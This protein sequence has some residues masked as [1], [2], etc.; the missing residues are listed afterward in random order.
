MLDPNYSGSKFQSTKRRRNDPTSS[1]S[2]KQ[3]CIWAC[4][5]CGYTYN[6]DHALKCV[7]CNQ[8]GPVTRFGVKIGG[9]SYLCGVSGARPPQ[10]V[11]LLRATMVKDGKVLEIVLDG[12][13]DIPLQNRVIRTLVRE[14][15]HTQMIRDEIVSKCKHVLK[16]GHP[17]PDDIAD[18]HEN[19]QILAEKLAEYK[20]EEEE[21]EEKRRQSLSGSSRR[22][23]LRG[24]SN[25]RGGG[26]NSRGGSDSRGDAQGIGKGG[27]FIKLEEFNSMNS[28]D[29]GTNVVD[30]ESSTPSLHNDDADEDNGSDSG[31][32]Y[33]SDGSPNPST[34][35]G[36]SNKESR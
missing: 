7:M 33:E 14:I 26:S 27:S 11:D 21:E 18:A 19:S 36:S 6:D 17:L 34:P 28:S 35:E 25:S 10:K 24:R 4:E 9:T 5:I 12:T 20:K 29:S 13:G 2:F 8:R 32:D 22:G 16:I 15:G 1:T 3:L 31:A 23:S 30:L